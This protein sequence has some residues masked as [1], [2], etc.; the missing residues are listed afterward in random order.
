MNKMELVTLAIAIACFHSVSSDSCD[1]CWL[2]EKP[3]EI[4]AGV[5]KDMSK[6]KYCNQVDANVQHVSDLLAIKKYV[7]SRP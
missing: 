2:Y 3:C 4:L 5:G 7:A 1:E 6:K